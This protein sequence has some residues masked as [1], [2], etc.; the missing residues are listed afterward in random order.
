MNAPR[1]PARANDSEMVA[2]PASSCGGD[3]GP[4]GPNGAARP[5]SCARWRARAARRRAAVV[6][7][8]RTGRR[9]P[10]V[11]LGGAAG[12]GA[13]P[14]AHGG[15]EPE[16]V[17]RALHGLSGGEVLARASRGRSSGRAGDRAR[18]SVKS[19]L[20]EAAVSTSRVRRAARA[21]RRAARRAVVGGIRRAAE[22][23]SR[24]AATLRGGGRGRAR[25]DARY[26]G[27]GRGALERIGHGPR[28]RRRGTLAELV[29][30][31]GLP[32][33]QLTLH[34]GAR[35]RAAPQAS[36][37]TAAAR[38][39][40]R[41]SRTSRPN[42]R[43]A[44]A[45]AARATR[46]ARPRRA[47]RQPAGGV[48]R[49]D[50]K[51]AAQMIPV[52]FRLAWTNLRRDRVAQVMTFVLPIGFFSIFALVFGGSSGNGSTPR[53]HVL[54]VDESR[55]EI[56]RGPRAVAVRGGR[57]A[58]ET[59]A[60]PANAGPRDTAVALTRERAER[61]CA[62]ARRPSR[63]F[64]AGGHRH[65]AAALRRPRRE[66]ARALRRG[67]PGRRAHG[68]RPAA[69]RD[70]APVAPRRGV[71]AALGHRLGGR[72]DAR[73]RDAHGR[74]PAHEAMIA[75]YAAGIAVMFHVLRRRSRRRAHRGTS[76]ARSSAC[77][78]RA[79]A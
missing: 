76:R 64:A 50:R 56:E 78:D 18:D 31:A 57:P 5:R 36:R 21:A 55:T 47:R 44:R 67:G 8:P 51:G 22:K 77:S 23:L 17:R 41:A 33:R 7:R 74:R 43:T 14:A 32:G 29:A 4:L 27:G 24:H 54:V 66:G 75:F 37:S 15:R 34:L 35:S 48:P 62:P 58:R 79:S 13:L 65:V 39:S 1:D 10:A 53:V 40:P 19:F 73:R 3:V 61:S 60:R 46:G 11:E 16:R 9:T 6:V 59:K 25:H 52:L 28:T 12:A 49:A 26:L 30:V 45:R 69:A 2:V 70:A 71:T 63:S 20:H 72:D 68:G 42:F 38:R